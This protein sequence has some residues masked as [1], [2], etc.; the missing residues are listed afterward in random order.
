M[1]P[2]ENVLLAA[3]PFDEAARDAFVALSGDCNPVHVDPVAARR[4]PTGTPI[5]HGVHQALAALE[6]QFSSNPGAAAPV[7]KLRISFEKPLPVGSIA[8]IV[9]TRADES[10]F[11]LEVRSGVEITTKIVAMFGAGVALSGVKTAGAVHSPQAPL[12]HS[13]ADLVG[14]SGG[15]QLSGDREAVNSAFPATSTAIGTARVD[16]LL[17]TTFLVGMVAPGRNS[18]FRGLSLTATADGA[19][20]GR[21]AFRT[22]LYDPRFRLLRLSIE[23]GGWT[24]SVDAHLRRGPVVQPSIDA[25]S[26]HVKRGE[27]SGLRSLI[28]GGSRGLGEVIA[29]ILASGGADVTITY[30]KGS[31]DAAR[32]RSEIVGWGG[33]CEVAPFD[34][35]SGAE[36][37]DLIVRTPRDQVYFMATPPI[38]SVDSGHRPDVLARYLESYVEGFAAV[39]ERLAQTADRRLDVFY[40]STIYVEAPPRDFIDYAMAKAAGEVFCA[41]LRTDPR[42]ANVVV[43]RL[44]RLASDQTAGLASERFPDPVQGLLDAVR[45]TC[46]GRRGT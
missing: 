44:P 1:P 35:R 45:R 6:A 33:N 21:L 46:I 9:R 18:L 8:G 28:I 20:D 5:V 30:A 13:E 4:S 27:F 19:A 39:V 3:I 29:K 26:H 22:V 34:L 43:E 25:V 11:V 32:V 31:A 42:F 41:S 38:G 37:L 24:G 12:D 10:G 15:I 23:G 40:P 7:A 2:T 16:G 17:A 14:L 36:G